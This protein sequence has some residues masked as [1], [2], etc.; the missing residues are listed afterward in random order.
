MSR[1]RV[2]AVPQSAQNAAFLAVATAIALAMRLFLFPLESGDYQ[3]FLHPWFEALRQNGGLAAV[4]LEIG[5]YT[6]PYFYVLALLTYLPVRDLFSIKAVSCAAD[7]VLAVF[8]A[9]LA[10]GDRRL[11]QTWTAAYCAVL[12]LPSAFLNSAAWGQCDAMYVSALLAFVYYAWKGRD[13]AAAVSFGV[14]ITLKLQAVFLAPLFLLLL[15]KKR[16]RWRSVLAVPA[17]YVAA[18]LPAAAMGRNLW[19]LLTIYF[20]QAGQ[21]NLLAMYLPNLYTWLGDSADPSIGRA[22]IFLAGGVVLCA[23]FSSGSGISRSR[24]RIC[25]HWRSFLRC[26]PRF[27]FPTCTSGIITRPTCSA[28]AL[29][30]ISRKN[31]GCRLPCAFPPPMW[32]ATTCSR[33]IFCLSSS[34]AC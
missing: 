26:S 28:S 31:G 21:Y 22:G 4:G 20:R 7:V 27:C 11:S 10:S 15:L 14:S 25:W 13:V 9:N 24:C 2:P 30:S 8:A 19:D 33:R 6:P 1:E 34:S 29:R 5:D 18:C 3:Q 32:C 16:L 17:V 12:F 23:V